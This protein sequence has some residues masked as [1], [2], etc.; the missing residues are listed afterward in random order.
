ML[1]AN[2]RDH[3]RVSPL[4]PEQ[5]GP[6]RTARAFAITQ[7]AV[8][9]AFN[10]IAGGF[11]SYG[12]FSSNVSQKQKASVDAAIAQAAGDALIALF[13]SQGTDIKNVQLTDLST[14][15]DGTAKNDGITI[16]QEAAQHILALR[17]NDGS[18]TPDPTYGVGYTP[19]QAFDKWRRDPYSTT[20]Q[21]P[22]PALGAFWKNVTPF[23]VLSATQFGAAPV[24]LTGSDTFKAA[25]TEVKNVGGDPAFGTPTQRTA[26]QTTIGIFWG[27]DGT[28]FLGTPPRAYNQ[29]AVQIAQA[30]G[31]AGIKLAR[32][33]ALL[34]T[35][36]ADAG[37]ESWTTKFRDE[38]WRPVTSIQKCTTANACGIQGDPNF[39]PLGAP[40]SNTNNAPNFTP[41]FPAYTSGHATFGGALFQTLRNFYGTDAIPFSF[42]SDE[43]NGVTK[44]NK[45]NVRPIVLRTWNTLSQAEEENGQSRIYLGI[46]WAYDKTEGIKQGNLTANFVFG[47]SFRKKNLDGTLTTVDTP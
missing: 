37:L 22:G 5:G 9:N 43:F 6:L 11:E 24:P 17:N 27:Y 32:F 41:P 15:P 13:P 34:N 38:Y 19:N 35:A 33:L 45:G 44:D 28:P 8:F 36:L 39:H 10:N 1:K 25:F 29:I 12:G 31:T 20:D 4:S 40:A 2:A 21:N 3:A 46:H 42:I 26:E 47:H 18:Q 14:I 7:I 30:K 23:V 16:G